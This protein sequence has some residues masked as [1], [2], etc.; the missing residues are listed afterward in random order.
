M[1]TSNIAAIESPPYKVANLLF[2]NTETRI[3]QIL[4]ETK[5]LYSGRLNSSSSSSE[6]P[7]K[8]YSYRNLGMVT[9]EY[10]QDFECNEHFTW[11]TIDQANQMLGHNQIPWIGIVDGKIAKITKSGDLYD[12]S[13][14]VSHSKLQ[15]HGYGIYY[16]SEKCTVSSNDGFVYIGGMTKN[17][18]NGDAISYFINTSDSIRLMNDLNRRYLYTGNVKTTNCYVSKPYKFVGVM[19]RE[20]KKHG[21][22]IYDYDNNRETRWIWHNKF[23]IQENVS[24]NEELDQL[25][26]RNNSNVI[27]DEDNDDEKY[28]DKDNDETIENVFDNTTSSISNDIHNSRKTSSKNCVNLTNLHQLS[29]SPFSSSLSDAKRSLPLTTIAYSKKVKTIASTSTNEFNSNDL[30]HLHNTSITTT[31]K[32]TTDKP[33]IKV[34]NLNEP[35]Q[36]KKINAKLGKL[37][38]YL[39]LLRV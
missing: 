16:N 36:D 14:S 8:F 32:A 29:S 17:Q 9:R 33:I 24:L 2:S 25:Q 5:I 12:G 4:Q 34:E 38:V 23:I 35:L 28:I 30:M 18:C 26:C 20:R 11:I 22:A 10:M 39:L 19:C 21:I 6:K 3:L 27:D 7:R 13:W 1:A 37:F 31:A 15:Y